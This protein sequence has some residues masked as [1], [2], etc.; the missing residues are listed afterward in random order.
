MTEE[1]VPT[2]PGYYWTPR[3]TL[4]PTR[5]TRPEIPD[6]PVSTTPYPFTLRDASTEE[7]VFV[8]APHE[9]DADPTPTP[10]RKRKP[11][12][13]AASAARLESPYA[14]LG[15]EPPLKK[16]CAVETEVKQPFRYG[17]MQRT[18]D[19][20]RAERPYMPLGMQP[21]VKKVRNEGADTKHR[22]RSAHMQK[23]AGM[24][25][26]MRVQASAPTPLRNHD[27]I[28]QD[29]LKGNSVILT[30]HSDAY[31]KS[32]KQLILTAIR[33]SLQP[34]V[35]SETV[36][37]ALQCIRPYQEGVEI[38]AAPW[39]KAR[40]W[41]LKRLTLDMLSELF[42]INTILRRLRHKKPRLVVCSWW[43]WLIF[44]RPTNRLCNM[45]LCFLTTNGSDCVSACMNRPK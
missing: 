15:M 2:N 43:Q 34:V 45:R 23:I 36:V 44:Q 7:S 1:Y 27:S 35:E 32:Q 41:I 18:T 11:A 31:R 28:V 33:K 42:N 12:P 13:Y 10:L 25:R 26:S 9:D 4:N 40:I 14:P 38:T 3:P 37:S 8:R 24:H 20:R 39:K 17:Y 5:P 30:G 19:A 21:P 6:E 29:V 22:F 16:T